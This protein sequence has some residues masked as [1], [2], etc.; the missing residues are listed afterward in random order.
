MLT[1]HFDVGRCKIMLELRYSANIGP[2]APVPCILLLETTSQQFRRHMG[3]LDLIV[4]MHNNIDM[5][6]LPVE[7][8]LLQL[9]LVS[10]KRS[11]FFLF[12]VGCCLDASVIR[13]S[14]VV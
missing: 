4:H 10:L 11:R 6:L 8:P 1:S 2:S 9:Q 13:S 3:N 14:C 5:T 12:V 7:R